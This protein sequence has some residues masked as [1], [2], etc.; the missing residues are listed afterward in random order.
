MAN[1]FS[2]P[3]GFHLLIAT[4]KRVFSWS[5]D[6]LVPVFRSA[7]HGILAARQ[8]GDGRGIL[9][10]ADSQ[11]VILQNVRPGMSREYKLKGEDGELRVL[12][13][14]SDSQI[15][16]FTS[17]LSNA[18][19]TYSIAHSR[20]LESAQ[21]HPSPPT[22]VATSSNSELLLV[23]SDSPPTISIQNLSTRNQPLE[24]LPLASLS[25]VVCASF[26]PSRS[27]TFIL[28][29]AD[30]TLAAY[31]MPTPSGWLALRPPFEIG[32]YERLH[33]ASMGGIVAAEFIYG[34]DA[35]VASVGRDGKCRL[36]DFGRGTV[37]L[38]TWHISSPATSLS[39]LP[40]PKLSSPR[41]RPRRDADTEWKVLIAIGREDGKVL[42]FNTIGLLE[43]EVKV[44]AGVFGLQWVEDS[45]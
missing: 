41:R 21:T 6:G 35:R 16:F 24:F 14:S 32:R 34:Y 23:A 7:T 37:M 40:V 10:I 36:V 27:T 1:H 22:V 3:N 13:F 38:R 42:V 39:V 17:T 25:R 26:H 31:R 29:F 5:Q 4:H 43:R 33:K 44:G 19:Q 12:Q 45:P 15:L 30:G 20:F 28:G 11:I 18:V 9:A 8:S 2:F